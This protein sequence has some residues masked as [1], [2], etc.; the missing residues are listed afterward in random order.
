MDDRN[1]QSDDVSGDISA[2]FVSRLT[3]TLKNPETL[4]TTFE[5]RLAAA[6]RAERPRTDDQ[7]KLHRGWWTRQRTIR[8]S[9]LAGLAAAAGI[10]GVAIAGTLG[11]TALRGT[12]ETSETSAVATPTEVVHV[13]RFVFVDSVAHEVALVGDFNGWNPARNDLHRTGTRGAWTISIPLSSGRHEYAFV[14]DGQ[15]WVTD[16]F[17]TAVNDDFDTQSSVI[18][19]S[20][21]APS[22]AS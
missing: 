6:I 17:A 11:A 22:N 9:P 7:V 3:R 1:H 21:D 15:R 20:A 2:A 8:L 4:D 14:V 18:Q 5:Q 12:H 16:P 19:L 10:A 13:V